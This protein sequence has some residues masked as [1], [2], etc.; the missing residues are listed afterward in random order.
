M[1]YMEQVELYLAGERD[2]V[3]IRGGTGP[4]VYPAAHVYIYTALYY[5]T[6]NGKNILTGQ[7][8]FA[9]LYLITAVIVV[10]CYQLA[11]VG[12][13]Y[14][15]SL[16]YANYSIGS[17]LCFPSSCIVEKTAQCLLTSII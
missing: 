1:A 10:R 7:I 17:T 6:E 3:K 16:Y 12:A 11:K 15:T 8:I 13:P 4:L 2:Y 9:F 5:L 14:F